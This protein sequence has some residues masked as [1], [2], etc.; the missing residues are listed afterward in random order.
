MSL[1]FYVQKAV[2]LGLLTENDGKVTNCA[3]E[4]V[5]TILGAARIIEKLQPT[6][7]VE[8]DDTTD[9]EAIVLCR[10]LNSPSGAAKELWSSLRVAFGV[11]HNQAVPLNLWSSPDL[12]AI[13]NEIDR[14]Y[15]GERN[16]QLINRES[17]IAS[18]E[19]LEPGSRRVSIIDFNKAVGNLTAP[20]SM[21]AYGDAESEWAVALDLLRQARVKA[22]YHE[23]IHSITQVQKA[24]TKLEKSI[25]FQQRQLME[26]LGMLRG[27]V[28]QQGNAKT[29]TDILYG[30]NGKPGMID[31]IL[32]TVE[33]IKPVSTG[34]DAMDLDMEGGVYPPGT[35]FCGGRLFTLAAR[36]GVG[37]T[38]L[39]CQALVG[40]AA[41]GLK[42]GYLS[43]ELD[44]QE[45]WT[46][47]W[48][49]ATRKFNKNNAWAS[50][51]SVKQAPS[52]KRMEIAS[53]IQEA[54]GALQ[55]KGGEILVEAPWAADVDAVINNL[56]S[57]KAKN[58]ELRAAVVD[59]FHCMSRHRNAPLAEASMLEERAYRLTTTAKELGIDLI[60]LAQMN[61]VGMNEERLQGSKRP[62]PSSDQIRGTDAIAHL[63]HGVWLVRKKIASED[64]P[65]QKRELEF[66]HD[67]TRGRQAIWKDNQMQD[68]TNYV[69]CSELVMDY[70][71]CSVMRDDTLLKI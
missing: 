70:A 66:W 22:L 3:N 59:H 57:M 21:S 50:V 31:R 52:H 10:V 46:R 63:S 67:K 58:P 5:E 61:R 68:V 54:C 60:V 30:V 15:L 64:N 38:I 47:I 32:N 4:E 65:G 35:A 34:I 51:G 14:T 39:G 62:A 26:C 41:G 56:R 12:K 2:D 29:S 45:I 20:D 18:Y 9:Q 23:M 53:Y 6:T 24:D 1:P 42:V 44:E 69:E 17:L 40:L 13:G 11:A 16:A 19:L 27:S 49:C 37:K 7:A 33:Q 36:T 28:G 25:E 48:S 8:I 71:H 55:Q 43:A